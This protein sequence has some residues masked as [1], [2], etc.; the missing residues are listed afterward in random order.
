[1][2]LETERLHLR[3]FAESDLEALAK[4]NSDP[5]VVKYIS[6]AVPIPREQTEARLKFYIAHQKQ[7]GFGMKALIN[8]QDQSLIGFCGLQFLENTKEVEVGYRLAKAFWGKGLATEA[9]KAC[10]NY[11]FTKL[12]LLEIVAV[13]HPE[14]IASRKVIEK[15]GLSYE[16]IAHFYNMDLTYYKITRAMFFHSQDKS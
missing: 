14:N 11:G 7:H 12:N 6:N 4:I 13:V 1:M 10:L 5:E 8:K 3:T 15:I 2:I 16:K 9:A